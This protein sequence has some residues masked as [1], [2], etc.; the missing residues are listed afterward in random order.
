[1][2][3]RPIK[4]RAWDIEKKVMNPYLSIIEGMVLL[5]PAKPENQI[6]MQ[7]TG[8]LDKNGK[9]IYEGD[10]V[11]FT[12]FDGVGVVRFTA[13]EF[14]V[15]DT[16]QTVREVHSLRGYECEVTGNIHENPERPSHPLAPKT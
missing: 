11:R 12:T 15:S 9:E 1:M 5:T 6:V 16:R 13:P 10:I 4:F 3:Q 14:E 8:L 7:F 2:N